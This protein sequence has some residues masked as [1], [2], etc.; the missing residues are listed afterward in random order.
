MYRGPRPEPS[1][2]TPAGFRRPDPLDES[3]GFGVDLGPSGVP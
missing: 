3:D 2:T 1:A